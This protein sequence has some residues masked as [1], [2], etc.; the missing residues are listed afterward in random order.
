MTMF[1]NLFFLSAFLISFGAQ[2]QPYKT[3]KTYKP[4]KWMIGLHWT[5][6][7]DDGSGIKNSFDVNN[8]WNLKPFPT[9]FTLDRYFIYGWSAE[10][11]MSFA[12]Y[13]SDNLVNGSTGISGINLSIDFNGKYSFYNLYAPK[14]RWFDPYLFAGIGFTYRTGT[15]DPYVPTVNL[16]GG[17]N[18]WIVN[19][20]GIRIS[21]NAKFGVFPKIW[22]TNNNYLQHNVGLVFRTPDNP[23]HKNPN[24]KKRHKWTNKQPKKLKRKGGH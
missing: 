18:F 14:A 17:I 6:I 10:M 9:R 5:A 8:A 4:Y 13:S 20:F 15:A 3:I 16:G 1:K 24:D 12:Q 2:A 23:K 22:N 11:A 19:Q 21:S 7:D